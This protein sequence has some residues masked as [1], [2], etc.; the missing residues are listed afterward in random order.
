MKA[1]RVDDMF[2]TDENQAVS[3]V[4][5]ENVSGAS[6]IREICKF[7]IVITLFFFFFFNFETEA[8]EIV[9]S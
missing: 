3:E 5:L 6:W 1:L 9:F 2:I 4:T 8:N 7:E